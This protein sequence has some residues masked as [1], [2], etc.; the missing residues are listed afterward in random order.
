MQR[1][2]EQLERARAL[3]QA[4]RVG[5]GEELSALVN[6][7][8]DRINLLQRRAQLVQDQAQLAMWL[9]RPGTEPL[10]AQDPGILT[11]EP[12]P[13]PSLDD[14]ADARPAQRRPLVRALQQQVR[15]AELGEDV[16]PRGL[17][18][19][20]AGPGLLARAGLPAA[21]VPRLHRAQRLQNTLSPV[22]W[23]CSG[24]SSTASPRRPR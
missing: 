17:L 7:G 10:E 9:A 2:E 16:A 18:P 13:A 14:R 6:L 11:R 21:G 4:G 23:C 8:N 5:R 12:A 20:A 24:T 15:A 3:F 19:P 22:G 1:S